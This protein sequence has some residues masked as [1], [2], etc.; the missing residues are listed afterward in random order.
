MIKS[1]NKLR[2]CPP[3]FYQNCTN[4]Q[5]RCKQCIA[6]SGKQGLY[7]EPYA[8][9]EDHPASNWKQD[10]IARQKIQRQAKQTETKL[11]QTI[12]R[13]T[14]GSGAVNHDGDL[15]VAESIRVEVKRRGTRK[16][17][18]VTCQ[19]YDKGL[20]QGIDVF[21]IEIER[22]DTGD[23]QTLYCCTEDFFTSV[24]QAKL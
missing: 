8:I 6:G 18:N 17:W 9:L 16:S 21:A 11:A 5:V 20:L 3:R 10:K 14:V 4:A 19:E 13:K 7:Y 23:R 24:V 12:A 22:A 1:N 15:L 2:N